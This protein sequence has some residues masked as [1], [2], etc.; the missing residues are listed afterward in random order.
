M[1]ELVAL[2]RYAYLQSSKLFILAII[3]SLLVQGA[4]MVHPLL[5]GRIVDLY[6]AQEFEDVSELLGLYI[7]ATLILAVL[8]PC[9]TV[10]NQVAERAKQ[11]LA[12]RWHES[13]FAKDYDKLRQK[14]PGEILEI[15]DRAADYTGHMINTTM[16]ARIPG[17]IKMS[18]ILGY[19]IIMDVPRILT[20]L[21]ISSIVIILLSR[22][23][24][25]LL[26]PIMEQ[27]NAL[28]EQTMG[29]FGDIL[30]C[31][32][33]IKLLD[34]QDT[35]LT[36][37]THSIRKFFGLQSKEAVWEFASYNSAQLMVW[38][39]QAMIL[40]V[41]L[42]VI[43]SPALTVLSPGQILTSY[44]YSSMFLSTLLSLQQI[45]Y[46]IT[47]WRADKTP[48][49]QLIR[50][51]QRTQNIQAH[52]VDEG[53][54]TLMPF[55]LHHPAPLELKAKISLPFRTKTLITG[56]SG[57]GKSVLADIICGVH[58]VAQTVYWNGADTSRWSLRDLSQI[59]YY[60]K[61]Q[62]LT[63]KGDFCETIFYRLSEDMSP[64]QWDRAS[65]LLTALRLDHF[66]PD[67]HKPKHPFVVHGLSYGERKRLSLC[68]ALFL[69]RPVTILEHPTEGID[70]RLV[71]P[72]WELV[73]HDL[74]RSTLI[75]FCKDPVRM[76]DFDE[77]FSIIDHQIQHL[78]Q[79]PL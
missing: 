21:M 65:E 66:L 58:R 51:P 19:L 56:D 29:Q 3:I 39:T 28:C 41:G 74:K 34:V 26:R 76:K 77:H 24:A 8:F 13:F 16:E 72:L 69:Q 9:M 32:S 7:I 12:M 42:Q 79:R 36:P 61:P 54:C 11:Q 25:S 43:E 70:Q 37:F 5:L 50:L 18:M 59:F 27:T 23:F 53:E 46:D 64:E 67:L 49:D 48:L 15:F 40:F 31:G 4:L 68:R 75:C 62:L 60:A 44:L 38:L 33:T 71:D 73:F 30:R 22:R 14:S 47:A 52:L 2:I 45:F 78:V 6:S 17:V 55:S 63:L 10:V 57:V 35:A 20:L 1:G